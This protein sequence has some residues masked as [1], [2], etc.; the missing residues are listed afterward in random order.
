VRRQRRRQNH[1][2][3]DDGRPRRDRLGRRS[4]TGRR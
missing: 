1:L 3:A 4:Q 2:A